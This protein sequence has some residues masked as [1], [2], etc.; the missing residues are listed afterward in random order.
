MSNLA[1]CSTAPTP[2][3]LSKENPEHSDPLF[4]DPKLYRKLAGSL[5]YLSITRP[6]I[7][8]ATNR[9]CQHMHA[10]TDQNFKSLK[11]LLRYIKGT[12]HYGLPLTLSNLQLSTYT[13][14]DWASD[15]ADRKSISGFYTFLGDNQVSWEVK[16]QATVARSSTEA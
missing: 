1:E 7:V 14:A 6:D 15:N 9:I 16:K 8:F 13:D 4:S 10:P 5:Q 2:V 12:L 3:T 11:R